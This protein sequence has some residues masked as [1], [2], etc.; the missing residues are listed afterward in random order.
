MDTSMK[1]RE[2]INRQIRR[3]MAFATN[4]CAK[5]LVILVVL[6]FAL[7]APATS[8]LIYIFGALALGMIVGSYVGRKRPVKCPHCA[9][10]LLAPVALRL[11]K[12][13]HFCPTCGA[14]LE[15]EIDEAQG[16]QAG[17]RGRG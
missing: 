16:R 4:V 15:Q 3:S 10:P 7:G 8:P 14:S 17:L 13:Y 5:L 9:L 12:A 6:W 1:A 11:P 2:S